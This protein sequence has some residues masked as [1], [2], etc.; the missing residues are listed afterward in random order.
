MKLYT[1]GGETAAQALKTAQS[2]HGEDALV[3]KTKEIRKKT[4]TQPG[5]YEIVVAVETDELEGNTFELQPE[6]EI[7]P[8]NSVQKR[9][10]DILAKNMEKKKKDSKNP[11][12]DVT[13]QLSDAVRE[14]SK[15]A[16]MERPKSP[17][18][19]ESVIIPET[20]KTL[21]LRLENKIFQKQEDR[22]LSQQNDT[23][24]LK[25]IK[26]EL[27]KIND[28]IKLIQ[29]MFWDEKG[30][31][32]EGLQIP[33]EFAEIYRIAK[34]S[35]M[36]RAHLD[37]IM[38]LSL[39]LMPLKMREN[40]LTIK[41]YFRE[42]LRKM[43]Y[44]R[45]EHLDMGNKKIIML[46]GPTGV[47]KTTTLAKLAARYSKM[48]DKKYKVGI[49]TLDTYRIGAL[50]QLTWYARKMKISIET[51]IE[52]EDFLKEIDTLRYC[53]YILVDTAGHSQHDKQ[54]INMLKKFIHNDYKID[55][56]LVL[57]ATTKYEDLK[58]IY[59]SF[60]ELDIDTLIFSKLDESRG[61]G[62]LFSL[63]YESKKPVSYLSV[64]QEVPMDL[65]VATNDYLVDCML[66]GFSNSNRASK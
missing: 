63:V 62:N 2:K 33:Q 41:R 48:L 60:G 45:S 54:K 59:Q 10:D 32:N 5:L 3:V 25:H 17:P 22:A 4:M 49:I 53:D 38:K 15:I 8:K 20:P 12:E 7:K 16:G 30:P 42:V 14:I 58:D 6:E 26:T 23:K 21:D 44:C 18:K 55:I 36:N 50:E 37:E 51:V 27:D 29:N 56:T 31:K 66:D 35:G 43:I 52:P 28:K 34:N 47:G 1:Y 57:S 39:E 9:L 46:V 65:V 13:I 64:G 11:Y 61:L 40:S 19:K 24:E